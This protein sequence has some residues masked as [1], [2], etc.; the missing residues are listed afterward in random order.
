MSDRIAIGFKRNLKRT[1]KI[2][3]SKFGPGYKQSFNEGFSP[4]EQEASNTILSFVV[5]LS[6][7]T[8]HPY[9]ANNASNVKPKRHSKPHNPVPSQ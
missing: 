3:E 8:T 9:A 6:S 4:S 2:L 7:R 1:S 5:S